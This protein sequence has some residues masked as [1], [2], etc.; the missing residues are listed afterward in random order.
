[1]PPHPAA[2]P[3]ERAARGDGRA[4]SLW[5]SDGSPSSHPQS[6]TTLGAENFTEPRKDE[7]T[8]GGT[9]GSRGRPHSTATADAGWARPIPR[10]PTEKTMGDGYAPRATLFRG[11]KKCKKKMTPKNDTNHDGLRA[12]GRAPGKYMT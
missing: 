2:R 8:D 6:A 5:G 12:T 3:P 10:L 1:M 9:E 11:T 7:T 4:T